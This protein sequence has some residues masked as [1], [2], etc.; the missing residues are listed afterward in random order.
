MNNKDITVDLSAEEAFED[1]QKVEFIRE[2]DKITSYKF[3]IL[4][5]DNSPFE[6]TITRE[7]ME[8]IY[9]MY[10][11]EGSNLTQRTVSRHFPLYTLEEFK[12]ILR[13][14]NITKANAPFAPHQIEEIS[15]DKLVELNVKAKESDYLRKFEQER[16]TLFEKKYKELLKE[17]INYKDSVKNFTEI[18]SDIKVDTVIHPNVPKISNDKFMNVYLSDM[19]VGA[20]VSHYSL[21]NNVYNKEVIYERMQKVYDYIIKT[22]STYNI[23]NICILNLGDSLDGMDNQTTRRGHLLPQNLENKDQFKIYF[24]V[25]IALFKNLSECGLFK[26]ILYYSVGSDNHSGDFGYISN[27]AL[28]AAL[29]LVNPDIEVKIFDKIMDHFT[30]NNKTFI[31]HHGKDGR[32]MFRGMPLT[33]NDKVENYINQYINVNNLKGDIS[34][35]KGDLHQSATTF[36]ANFRYKSVASFFGSSEWAQANFRSVAPAVDIDILDDDIIFETRLPVN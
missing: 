6:G 27:K 10:S 26:K 21:Y 13:A 29:G 19:H 36:G 32:D 3:K 35:V 11:S 34:F 25:M 18:L 14:F 15:P 17:H 33:I 9:R 12:K 4:L 5:R 20:D 30:I 1:R 23:S 24:N 28:E 16:S 22:A 7:E 31:L 2:N 8:L